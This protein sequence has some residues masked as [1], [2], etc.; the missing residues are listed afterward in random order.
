[1]TWLS[2]ASFGVGV[3]GVALSIYFFCRQ[4]KMDKK[5]ENA[6]R[7]LSQLAAQSQGIA[8]NLKAIREGIATHKY[9]DMVAIDAAQE[10]L[11][12]NIDSFNGEIQNI[13]D[14]FKS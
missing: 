7:R 2:G 11:Q 5:M 10:S 14:V 6:L 4:R 13:Y 12:F 1:M 3:V 9:A 8:N